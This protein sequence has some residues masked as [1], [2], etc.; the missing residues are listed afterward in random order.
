[1]TDAEMLLEARAEIAQLTRERA[2]EAAKWRDNVG[3]SFTSICDRLTGIELSIVAIKQD[4]KSFS[5]LERRVKALEQFKW[6]ATGGGLVLIFLLKLL[7][8]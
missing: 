7:W 3:K 2:D 4:E 5:D 6:V 1:M 8:K